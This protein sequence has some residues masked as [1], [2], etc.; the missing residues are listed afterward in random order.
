MESVKYITAKNYIKLPIKMKVDEMAEEQDSH[1]IISKSE[2][3]KGFFIYPAKSKEE[4]DNMSDGMSCSV[5]VFGEAQILIE[6]P[7]DELIQMLIEEK[8]I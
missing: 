4:T 2:F 7:Q 5:L 8:M 6:K 1:V 3:D